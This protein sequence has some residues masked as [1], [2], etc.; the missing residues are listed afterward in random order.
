MS[1]LEVVDSKGS[2]IKAIIEKRDH[3]V[4][5]ACDASNLSGLYVAERNANEELTKLKIEIPYHSRSWV[6]Y[7]FDL[8]EDTGYYYVIHVSSAVGRIDSINGPFKTK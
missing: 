3:A 6:N 7:I 8:I 5:K 4:K 2:K 1:K